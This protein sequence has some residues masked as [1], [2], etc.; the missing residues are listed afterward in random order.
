[1]EQILKTY[2]PPLL[3]PESRVPELFSSFLAGA[4]FESIGPRPVCIGRRSSE[5]DGVEGG[6]SMTYTGVGRGGGHGGGTGTQDRQ[7]HGPG[8]YGV[9]GPGLKD[10]SSSVGS[11]KTMV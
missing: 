2:R 6:L 3:T 4:G 8:S 5:L 11:I 9:I 10:T 1:M 7:G